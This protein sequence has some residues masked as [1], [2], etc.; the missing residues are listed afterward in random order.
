MIPFLSTLDIETVFLETLNAIGQLT[1][2]LLQ[3][4]LVRLKASAQKQKDSNYCLVAFSFF[5][6]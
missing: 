2:P 5:F 1:V 4:Q 6:N 3:A